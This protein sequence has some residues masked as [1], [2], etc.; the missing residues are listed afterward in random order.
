MPLHSVVSTG[1][2]LTD[3]VLMGKKKRSVA[4]HPYR[5]VKCAHVDARDGKKD[6]VSDL[7]LTARPSMAYARVFCY[8]EELFNLVV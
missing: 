7:A 2:I 5:I 6:G 1:G 4:V 3:S 8:S